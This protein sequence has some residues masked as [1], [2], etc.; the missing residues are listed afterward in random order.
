MKIYSDIS[1]VPSQSISSTQNKYVLV[2][3]DIDN[4][5]RKVSLTV[6]GASMNTAGNITTSLTAVLTGPSASGTNNLIA[7]SSGAKTGSIQNGT[8]WVVANDSSTPDPDGQAFIFVSQSID[9]AGA[10]R[11]Y[12][13]DTL[14]QT[15]A[16]LRYVKLSSDVTQSITSSLIISGSTTFSGS[17]FWS[18]ASNLGG[19]ANSVLVLGND[20]K[21]Y[22][23]GAYGVGG[24]GGGPANPGGADKTIQFNDGGSSFSGSGNFTFDK[25]TNIV[26]LTGSFITSGSTPLRVIGGTSNITGSLIVSSSS[27]VIGVSRVTGSF[28]VSSSTNLIGATNITGSLIVSSSSNV[29]GTSRITGSLIISSSSQIIGTET[30]TGSLIVSSS[31]NVI[32]TSRVTGSLIV[33]N[34]LQVIGTGTISGSLAIS[35]SIPGQTVLRIIGTGS[36]TTAP[37]VQIAGQTGAFVQVYDFNSGSLF[38]VNSNTGT[39]I[40]DIVSNG[41]T[42]IGSNTYQGMYDSTGYALMP[43]PGQVLTIP[44]YLTNTYNALWFE[45]FTTSGSYSRTGT[46]NVIWSGSTSASL[47]TISSFLGSV[48]VNNISFSASISS[49]YMQLIAS[50]STNGWLIKGSIRGI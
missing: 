39:A 38:S 29:I 48:P 42:L 25:N 20:G 5:I 41:Q 47:D 3:G 19:A 1:S 2:Q 31:S 46:F 40:I 37:M 16:D 10:G 4:I 49:S 6:N 28:I 17:L 32:G 34:S 27:N 36:N 30:I 50:A 7:S 24:G 11:W 44:G 8:V 18:G 43:A 9:A 26:N 21:L 22:I 35:S 15:Q 33:S 23:T 13:L 14:N 12:P 45:Y